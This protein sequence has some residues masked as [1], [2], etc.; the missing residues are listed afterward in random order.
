[1]ASP[2]AGLISGT[3]LTATGMSGPPV[4]LLFAARKYP[5]PV[6]RG[7]LTVIFYLLGFISLTVLVVEGLVGRPE[8]HIALAL[9][10]ASVI[11]TWL[12][13]RAL[14]RFTPAEFNRIVLLLLMTTGVVGLIVALTHLIW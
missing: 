12:G 2:A 4:I 7:S 1:M 11:G 8:L 3:L 13:H 9:L 10:P 6:F 5:A 14:H